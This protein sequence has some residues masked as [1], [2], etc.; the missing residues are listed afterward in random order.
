MNVENKLAKA[1][2]KKG[3]FLVVKAADRDKVLAEISA[4]A[5]RYQKFNPDLYD[6]EDN[7]LS[8]T[9]VDK[10]TLENA[11]DY[12]LNKWV[13]TNDTDELV[14]EYQSNE[15]VVALQCTSPDEYVVGACEIYANPEDCFLDD[16]ITPC[17]GDDCYCEEDP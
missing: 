1:L 15:M 14:Y 4:R 16:G 5:A 2:E 3:N 7:Y 12:E 13:F 8:G 6:E 17:R 9:G 11:Y 10:Y